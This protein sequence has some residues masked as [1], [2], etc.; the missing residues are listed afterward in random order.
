MRKR[1]L[2]MV[3]LL[4]VAVCFG[5]LSVSSVLA[6]E[7]IANNFFPDKHPLA[8]YPYVEWA[9]DLEKASGGKLKAKIF[10]GTV[11]LEPRAGLSGVRDGVAQVGYHAAMYT[12]ADL[13]VA[14]ALQETGFSYSDPLVAM[15][16]VTEFSMTDPEQMAEWKKAGIVFGGGYC[17]PGYCLMCTQPV[18][19]MKEVKGK[20]LRTS[21]AANSRWAES[22]GAVPV[23]VPSSEMY[24]GLEKGSIDCATNVVSDLKDRSLWD[25]AKHT[26]MISLGMYWGGW[27]WGWNRDYWNKE[28]TA[29]ERRIIFDVSA[30]AIANL[31]VGYQKA[32]DDAL[33]QAAEH[34]VNVYQPSADLL[35]SLGHFNTAN[36]SEMVKMAREKYKIQDPE[37]LFARFEKVM[38]KWQSRFAQV[39]RKDAAAIGKIIKE[40]LYDK[41]DAATYG[42]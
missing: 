5:A 41:I 35:A 17:T 8:K 42:K 25:V 30:Q 12:P 39:D 27:E 2:V 29:D 3:V 32:M 37:A 1:N 34:K 31:Y 38:K 19:D 23:N 28:L 40:E 15:V 13:P 7:F 24:T 21:G 20:K 14:N 16:A 4:A 11:L 22:V 18:R 36:R 26:T 10:T 6:K 33:A 9:K